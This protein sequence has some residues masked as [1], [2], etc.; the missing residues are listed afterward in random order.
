MKFQTE[1]ELVN[2]LKRTLQNIYSKG[3]IEIF[4]EV[5]LGYGIADVVVCN[6]V[7]PRE[8]LEDSKYI[9][10]SFDI[11]VYSLISK[12]ESISFDDI[13]EITRNSKRSITQTLKILIDCKYV[14]QS[15]TELSINNDYELIFDLSFAIE[16]KLKNWKRALQ[17]AYRYKW[18]AEYSYVVMDSFYSKSAIKNID[19]FKKYNVGLASI[20]PLGEIVRHFSP[21]LEK[22]FDPKM[23]ILFSEKIKTNY[24]PARKDFQI[25]R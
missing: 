24:E 14:R 15:G 13:L 12:S 7:K 1:I 17:Q 5:S 16:A 20:S 21:V 25:S 22:P 19:Q 2:V 10:S 8:N 23:Q 9:L 4:D 6:L 11:N 18:F 3:N